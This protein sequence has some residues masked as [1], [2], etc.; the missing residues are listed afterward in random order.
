MGGGGG[1]GGGGKPRRRIIKRGGRHNFAQRLY[2]EGRRELKSGNLPI[3]AGKPS[4]TEKKLI[5]GRARH[6]VTFQKIAKNQKGVKSGSLDAP[7]KC[8]SVGLVS[9]EWEWRGNKASK[10]SWRRFTGK[11]HRRR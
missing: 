6:P 2:Q 5:T 8:L 10:P 4:K 9:C 1:G 7:V 11:T 3:Q